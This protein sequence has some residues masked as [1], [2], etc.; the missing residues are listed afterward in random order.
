MGKIQY[1]RQFSQLSLGNIAKVASPSFRNA[2][3]CVKFIPNPEVD[4]YSA[5]WN[6]AV[7]EA[8]IGAK[9]YKSVYVANRNL[10][11][12]CYKV[13]DEFRKCREGL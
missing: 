9:C 3:K 11:R 4:M 6:S 1:P 8:A 2:A 12:L 5:H 13:I 7:K 10:S